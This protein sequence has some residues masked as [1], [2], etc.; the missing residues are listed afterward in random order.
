MI[1]SSM[2]KINMRVLHEFLNCFINKLFPIICQ[3]LLRNVSEHFLKTR[4]YSIRLFIFK[5]NAPSKFTESVSWNN[6]ETLFIVIDMANLWGQQCIFLSA[7]SLF[8]FKKG[9]F[10]T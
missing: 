2:N 1:G 7:D 6:N 3:N 4:S 9:V 5:K 8:R 10:L